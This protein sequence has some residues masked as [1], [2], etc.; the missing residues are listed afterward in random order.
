VI[1]KEKFMSG[2]ILKTLFVL[3][4]L[5]SVVLTQNNNLKENNFGISALISGGQLDIIFP[6]RVTSKTIVAPSLGYVFVGDLGSDYR[7]GAIARFYLSDNEVSPF[8]GFRG[9]AIF[10]SRIRT[11]NMTDGIVGL[12]GGAEYFINRSI[13]AGVEAQVNATFSGTNSSRFGNP[14][15]TNVNSATA[16]YATIYF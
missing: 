14:G 2:K 16:I 11:D 7:I 1:Q 12:L 4:I 3:C 6:I 5:Q 10:G 13:S 15:K 9:G 8:I